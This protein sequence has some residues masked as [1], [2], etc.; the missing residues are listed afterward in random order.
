V[1]MLQRRQDLSLD[2]KAP[3]EIAIGRA[4]HDLEG[5]LLLELAVDAVGQVDGAH[6]PAS[7]LPDDPVGAE[8]AAD[9]GIERRRQRRRGLRRRRAER[10]VLIR[11]REQRRDLAPQVRVAAAGAIEEPVALRPGLVQRLVEQRLDADPGLGLHKGPGWRPRTA[12]R[13]R[14]LSAIVRAVADSV[15]FVSAFEDRPGAED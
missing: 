7:Q 6:P 12:R 14:P 10:A 3:L 13:E 4:A 11:E 2:A 5:D 9:A 15:V 1:G 8:P